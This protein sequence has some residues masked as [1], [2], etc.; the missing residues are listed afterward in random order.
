[1]C[2]TYEKYYIVCILMIVLKV[3]MLL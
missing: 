3:A 1:M 2:D